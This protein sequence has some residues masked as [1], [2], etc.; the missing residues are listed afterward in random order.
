MK[1]I[2]VLVDLTPRSEQ[3][4]RLALKIARQTRANLLLCDA[5]SAPLNKAILFE[6]TDSYWPFEGSYY[7]NA[8]ELADELQNENTGSTGYQPTIMC[9]NVSDLHVDKLK[10]TIIDNDISM[11]M[12]GIDDMRML[13]KP[14][15]DNYALQLLNHAT[16]PVL[17][18][19]ESAYFKQIDKIAYLTDLRYCSLQVIRF[20]KAFDVRI[21]ITHVSANGIPDMEDI[22]AQS[23]LSDEIAH[24]AAYNKIFLRNIKGKNRKT[25]FEATII[26]TDISMVTLVNKK[27]MLLESLLPVHDDND[28]VYYHLPLLVMPYLNWHQA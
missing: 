9:H 24:K 20:L 8:W 12:M 1:N 26:D 27:H 6:Q 16:C 3:V 17:L 22:Y 2:L 21:Y 4:A 14:D 19:P 5:L 28:R 10:Q 7:L 13:N 23:L 11:I 25:D 18:I 15:P